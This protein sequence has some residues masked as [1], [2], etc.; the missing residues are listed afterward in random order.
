M[1]RSTRLLNRVHF[2]R[3]RSKGFIWGVGTTWSFPS[4]TSDLAGSGEWELGPAG[5]AFFVAKE[6]IFGVFPQQWFSIGGD[7]SRSDVSF[8]DLSYFAWR[9]L[10]GGWQVGFAQDMTVNWKGGSGNKVTLPIGFGVGRTFKIG[11]RAFKVDGQVS[12]AVVHPDVNG[13]RWGIKLRFTPIINA[14]CCTG[15]IF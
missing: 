3:G 1:R 15:T 9:L 6:W 13:Q 5:A 8:L 7:G 11:S 10:P 2:F 4:A 12:Y 14:L